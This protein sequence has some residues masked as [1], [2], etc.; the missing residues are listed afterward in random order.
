MKMEFKYL[1]TVKMFLKIQNYQLKIQLL[2]MQGEK[3]FKLMMK[4]LILLIIQIL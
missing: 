3:I 4:I 2:K 1:K